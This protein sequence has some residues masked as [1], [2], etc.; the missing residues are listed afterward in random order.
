MASAKEKDWDTALRA[1]AEVP[2]IRSLLRRLGI[3]PRKGLGQNFLVDEDVLARIMGVAEIEPA[4][5]VVEVGPGLGILTRELVR[6]AARVVAVEIDPQLAEIVLRLVPSAPNLEVVNADVLHFDP[7]GHGI[8]PPYKVVANLPYYITSPTMRHFLEEV[9]HPDVMVVMVQREVA[10]RMV[11]QPGEMSLLSVSV[12]F[13]GDA[14]MAA[15][16]PTSAF[17]PQPKVESA[18][19]RIDVYPRPVLDVEPRSF[20][21]LV[22]AGFSQPR[23]QLHNTLA[24]R[25]W[26]PP[27]G[28]REALK[29][30]GIDPA[31][32]AQTL[33]LEE[34]G[35]LW[36]VLTVQGLLKAEG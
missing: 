3:R 14:R 20:F 33:S 18:I 31:R 16:V 9:P 6:R 15:V 22:Q 25:L 26:F 21:R 27:G 8:T 4:D 29:A 2:A 17:Y 19:V 35:V 32:R 34:W 11:A 7:A 36:K 28:A 5:V 12:Q 10:E 24:Q 30:A 13:Y 1:D 23:K